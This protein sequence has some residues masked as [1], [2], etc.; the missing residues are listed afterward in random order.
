LRVWKREAEPVSIQKAE[1]THLNM[2]SLHSSCATFYG[3]EVVEDG[4]AQKR[5]RF[6]VTL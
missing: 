4:I 6:T 1:E 2:S 5:L 3:M